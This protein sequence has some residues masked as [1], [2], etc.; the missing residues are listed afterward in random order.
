LLEAAA[1]GSIGQLEALQLRGLQLL[2]ADFRR[3]T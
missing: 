1:T 3:T 2:A